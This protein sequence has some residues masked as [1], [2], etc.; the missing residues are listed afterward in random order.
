MRQEKIQDTQWSSEPDP[1]RTEMLESS[2]KEFKI[3]MINM[4]KTLAEKVDNMG[5]QV[6]SAGRRK[7]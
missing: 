1:D 3:A 2:N 5:N 6:I 4:L 7:L